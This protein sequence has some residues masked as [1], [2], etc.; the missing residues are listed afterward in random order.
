M[1]RLAPAPA[2]KD[3]RAP[4]DDMGFTEEL[5]LEVGEEPARGECDMVTINKTQSMKTK[6]HR[7]SG[8]EQHFAS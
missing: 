4:R 3:C 6:L 7:Y 2:A 1:L 5:L 8:L